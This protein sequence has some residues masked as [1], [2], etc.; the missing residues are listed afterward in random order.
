MKKD[1][2]EFRWQSRGK[3]MFVCA[4]LFWLALTSVPGQ[5]PDPAAK[6]TSL[7]EVMKERLLLMHEVAISKW[8]EKS[9]IE[10][11]ERERVVVERF[12]AEAKEHNLPADFA[13]SFLQAQIDAAKIL[14]KKYFT[15]WS[16][17][18]HPD[19]ANARDLK[20]DL[21]AQLD[22]VTNKL[23][24]ALADLE[25]AHEGEDVPREILG[26]ALR[27]LSGNGID[28]VVRETAIAPFFND[29]EPSDF[30]PVL[31][32]P[33]YVQAGPGSFNHQALQLVLQRD[34]LA[35]PRI[36]FCGTP[37][38]TMRQ[39]VDQSG[40]AF[41]ALKNDLVP[42]NLVSATVAAVRD[43]EIVEVFASLSMKIEM[44]LLRRVEAVKNQVP[45]TKIASHPSALQQIEDWKQ[46]HRVA[47]IPIPEGTSEAGRRLSAGEMEPDVGVIGPKLLA[48]FLP[49]L[50]VVEQGIEDRK[51]NYT[52]F[53][54]IKVRQRKEP[55]TEDQARAELWKI[56]EM[57][58]SRDR[59]EFSP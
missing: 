53:A 42:G 14:Q 38:N 49:H 20:T 23:F 45:L 41:V 47:E 36:H 57:T 56:C 46:A 7:M 32:L 33:L 31:K 51:E 17:E 12:T 52:Q 43:F 9:P 5:Q 29:A 26:A 16:A 22:L 11:L 15:T 6:V 54:L 48:E 4:G 18:N 27:V 50:V 30:L 37:A 35:D 59:F 40:L 10:D 2:F 25:L 44:C 13:T 28:E 1:I 19:F 58:K 21:R 39:A 3:R 24:R 8:N 55:M 34:I